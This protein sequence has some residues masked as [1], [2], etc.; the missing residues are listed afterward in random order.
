MDLCGCIPEKEKGKWETIKVRS[1]KNKAEIE[2]PDGTKSF[3]FNIIDE[4]N[5]IVSS[6]YTEI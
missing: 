3:F 5:L 1:E 2:I 4:R 6:P